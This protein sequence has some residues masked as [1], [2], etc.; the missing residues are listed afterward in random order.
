MTIHSD[1]HCLCFACTAMTPKERDEAF[2]LETVR[3]DAALARRI[4]CAADEWNAAMRAA[5]ESG[6]R[7]QASYP[8]P[9]GRGA[10][11]VEGIA[12]LVDL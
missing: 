12:R 4:R 1:P 10:I 9:S 6:V 11:S 5:Q 7:V 3:S 2:V 8:H